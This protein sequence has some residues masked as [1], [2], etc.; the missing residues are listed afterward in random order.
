[1]PPASGWR[2]PQSAS[3]AESARMIP[4]PA[5]ATVE[6][7]RLLL[8]PPRAIDLPALFA[9]LGDRRTMRHTHAQRS[10]ATCAAHVW[11]HERQRRRLGY[12]PWVI[13]TRADGRIIGWGGLYNDPFDAGW[14]VELGYFLARHAWGHGYASELA[15]ACMAL[16]DGTLHLRQVRGFASPRNR[17]SRR[18]LEKAGF[19]VTGYVPTMHRLLFS[20]RPRA[21]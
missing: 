8:R 4:Y 6:T 19:T 18:V 11:T 7:A 16:A 20:R 14:G 15:G 9:I 13:A 12:A 5:S 3:A 21:R 17:G 1:M 10:P 2:L